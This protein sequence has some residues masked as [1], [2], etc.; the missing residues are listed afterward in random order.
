MLSTGREG[1]QIPLFFAADATVNEATTMRQAKADFIGRRAP[2][3][4][5]GGDDSKFEFLGTISRK[6]IGK[7]YPDRDLS[8]TCRARHRGPTKRAAPSSPSNTFRRSKARA[9]GD[10]FGY[11]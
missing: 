8:R 3:T 1:G 11:S 10:Q 6:Y 2:D 9:H 5:T 4:G 7:P